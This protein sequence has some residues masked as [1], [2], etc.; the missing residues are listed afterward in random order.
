MYYPESKVELRGFTAKHYDFL[1]STLTLGSHYRM[2]GKAIKEMK[3]KDGERILDPGAGTG[4][5]ACMML[6]EA[7]VKIT[8]MDISKE[9]ISSFSKRCGGRAEIVE[10]RIDISFEFEE[11][12][13]KA[14]ISFVLHGFPHEVRLEIIKNVHRNL[15]SNGEFFILDYSEFSIENAPFI[16]KALFKAIEC[17]Y[18]FDYI[19]HDW[20]KILAENEFNKF[21]E[22]FFFNGYVRLLGAVKNDAVE[23]GS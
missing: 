23:N 5:I 16:V 10:R 22:K 13:D 20:K 2:I 21:R 3:L 1:I 11:K 9:M 6:D 15:M 14:F 7:N 8:A 17:P 12:F 18:A 4:R 19:K